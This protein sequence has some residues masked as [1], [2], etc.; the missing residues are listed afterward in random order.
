MEQPQDKDF[1]KAK[2]IYSGELLLFS[3]VF[4]TLG[5]LFLLDVLHISAWKRWLFAIGPMVGFVWFVIDL[6]WTIKS[7][8][9]RARNSLADKIIMVPMSLTLTVFAIIAF[10]NN[11]VMTSDGDFY[12]RIMVGVALCYYSGAYVFQAIYHW[13]HP[14]PLLIEAAKEDDEEKPEDA[15]IDVEAAPSEEEPKDEPSNEDSPAE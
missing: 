9:R 7:P 2:K 6:I 12:Y 3:L 10:I 8:K 5:I 13:Y 11:W 1:I 14:I 4:L 15:P